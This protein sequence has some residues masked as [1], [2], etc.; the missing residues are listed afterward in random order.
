MAMA[1]R[2]AFAIRHGGGKMI[3]STIGVALLLVAAVWVLLLAVCPSWLRH[4]RM[5]PAEWLWRSL[6]Y[7]RIQPLRVAAERA[8][9]GME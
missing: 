4:F 2:Y 1:S 9:E 7:G 5:G 3:R 6:T 8:R